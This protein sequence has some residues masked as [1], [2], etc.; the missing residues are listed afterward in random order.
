[1]NKSNEIRVAI[2][3]FGG[4]DNSEPG[5]AVARA[6]KR[7][8]EG[9]IS[10]DALGYDPWMTGAFS[11]GLIDNIHILPPLTDGDY[12]ILE[13]IIEINNK[14]KFH[15][16]IPTLELEIAVLSR[17]EERL[18]SK[19]IKILVPSNEHVNMVTKTLLPYFCY[20]NKIP[21]PITLHVPKDRKSTRLN[22]T[23]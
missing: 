16:I 13:R 15:A 20:R 11:P 12:A 6:L 22:S 4:L 5:T 3:G 2:T 9:K 23:H 1:M 17:L 14:R 18:K 8:W 21:T 19:G 7:G 10:I